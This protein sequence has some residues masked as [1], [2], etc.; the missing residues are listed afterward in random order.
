MIITGLSG[1]G[2]D[3]VMQQMIKK[4]GWTKVITHSA[5]RL[6]RTGE[7]H[8]DDY[9]FVEVDEFL[10]MDKRGELAEKTQYGETWKGTTKK[11]LLKV[12]GG[13]RV[14]WRIDPTAAARVEEIYRENFGSEEAEL[15]AK[16]TVKVFLRT[17]SDEVVVQRAKLRNADGE[18]EKISQRLEKDKIMWEELVVTGGK[19]PYVVVNKEG[20][21]EKTVEEVRRIAE[22]K[23]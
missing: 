18:M 17:E 13:K 23:L 7:R 9:F 5:G 6:P 3:A 1:S 11:E 16:K 2:K 10:E 8:G 21:L 15:L 22:A 20:E 12:L 14:I 19:F 4:Y